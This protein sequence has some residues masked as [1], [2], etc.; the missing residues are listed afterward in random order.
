[1]ASLWYLQ[2]L[3]WALSTGQETQN[4]K[5]LWAKDGMEP[6]KITDNPSIEAGKTIEQNGMM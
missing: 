6:P 3:H 4:S 2:D 1:M 5:L